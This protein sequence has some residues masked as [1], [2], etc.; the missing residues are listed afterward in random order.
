MKKTIYIILFTFLGILLQFL[1]HA[2]VE[3]WYINLLSLN[4][5]KYGFGLSWAQWFTIH[6]VL[7][8][9]LLIAGGLFGFFAGKFAWKKIYEKKINN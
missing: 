6:S 2:V 4:F 1:L 7:T 8:I 5:S 3:I 9:I